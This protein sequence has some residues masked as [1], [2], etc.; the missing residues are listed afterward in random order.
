MSVSELSLE[1]N[2]KLKRSLE[3]SF[4]SIDAILMLIEYYDSFYRNQ[5]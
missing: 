3:N 5:I 2:T 4:Q 1:R